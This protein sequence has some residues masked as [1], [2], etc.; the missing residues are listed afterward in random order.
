MKIFSF[1]SC[2]ITI[3]LRKSKSSIYLPTFWLSESWLY[4]LC[5]KSMVEL[6]IFNDNLLP[7]YF[8]C[9]AYFV[10]ASFSSTM[11]VVI[12]IAVLCRKNGLTFGKNDNLKFIV[13]KYEA[14]CILQGLPKNV[15][16]STYRA[17]WS[18]MG[19]G[20]DA[21]YHTKTRNFADL[22]WHDQKNVST[23]CLHCPYCWTKL[24]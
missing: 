14:V 19:G 11:L 4:D 21:S 22:C 23:P 3:A 24:N 7:R 9:C 1:T 20:G 15:L 16:F 10:H 6:D 5:T 12:M 8:C 18:K 17:T 13:I 2:A